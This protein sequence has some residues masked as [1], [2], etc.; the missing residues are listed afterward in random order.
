MKKCLIFILFLCNVYAL[1]GAV[2]FWDLGGTLLTTSKR[3]LVQRF[4]PHVIRELVTFK[5][6]NP[7]KSYQDFVIG[8]CINTLNQI[9]YQAKTSYTIY[10][11]DGK[12]P[13]PPLMADLLNGYIT[14][15]DILNRYK[16]WLRQHPHYSNSAAEKIVLNTFF[17][18]P[19]S[20]FATVKPASLVKTLQKCAKQVDKYGKKKHVNI[21]L[22]NWLYE[23]IEPFK[24]KFG[25]TI[26]AY[27]N[28][29]VFSGEIHMS[30]PHHSI[31]DYCYQ[32]VRKKFPEQLKEPFFFVDDQEVNLEGA[33][34]NQYHKF[35]CALP[36]Q[37]QEV[38]KKHEVI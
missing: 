27:M 19:K 30:K 25:T 21:I 2:I 15:N 20:S 32:L 36:D 12:T 23:G 10:A 28:D 18:N 4:N 7:R 16:K 38:L 3:A 9:P 33:R 1:N 5:F 14:N 11:D 13:V 6:K 17:E 29:A 37:A 22:S 24:K 26:M 31:Y 8:R 34:K 35:I